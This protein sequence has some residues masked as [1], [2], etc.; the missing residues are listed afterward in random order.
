MLDD[1][2]KNINYIMNIQSTSLT[3]ISK[4]IPSAFPSAFLS[5]PVT[6][7]SNLLSL[8]SSN[9][10]INGSTGSSGQAL[11]KT[12]QLEWIDTTANVF[13]NFKMGGPISITG[14]TGTINFDTPFSNTTN[15]VINITPIGYGTVTG[16]VNVIDV[17]NSRFTWIAN[18]AKGFYYFAIGS[19]I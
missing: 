16:V 12:N 15:V 5:A 9:I 13:S 4:I 14:V 3:D 7:S 11:G 2:K 19:T 6:I 8:T 17:N 1:I 18:N 10:S